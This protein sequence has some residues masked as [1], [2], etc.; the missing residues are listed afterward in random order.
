LKGQTSLF[1]SQQLEEEHSFFDPFTK[2][3]S[4]EENS[5]LK[6]EQ[7]STFSMPIKKMRKHSYSEFL[8]NDTKV[9]HSGITELGF[10]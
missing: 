8:E 2:Q 4:G 10:L 3:N 9:A 6:N 7:S 5:N 1:T